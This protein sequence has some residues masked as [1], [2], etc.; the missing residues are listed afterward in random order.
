MSDNSRAIVPLG[1]R[2]VVVSV[3]R[4]ITITEKLLKR[5]QS[6]QT[7]TVQNDPALKTEQTTSAEWLKKAGELWDKNDWPGLL[8]YSLRWT[9]AM[10]EDAE[11]WYSMGIAYH[12]IKQYPK[13]IEAYQQAIRINPEDADVWYNLGH[14]YCLIKQYPKAIEAYQ[15]AVRINPGFS[16]FRDSLRETYITLKQY[17]EAIEVCQQSIRIDPEDASAWHNLGEAYELNGQ[18]GK[19]MEVYKRLKTLDPNMADKFFNKN[20]LP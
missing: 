18:T 19:V 4:Q 5:I 7:Q 10:H 12:E 15:Q 2:G 1:Q 17:P 20:M 14:V 3:T 13:A 8:N 16:D 9:Q 6:A 11:A